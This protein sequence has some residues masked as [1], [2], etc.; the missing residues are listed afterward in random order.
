MKKSIKRLLGILLTASIAAATVFPMQSTKASEINREISN[1]AQKEEENTVS[2]NVPANIAAENA[3]MPSADSYDIDQPVIE[4]FEFLENGQ[5][6]TQNDT[7]HFNM[8]SP[9]L[10][11]YPEVPPTV[12][13]IYISNM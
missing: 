5:A 2:A 8:S 1:V 3:A 4:S 9:L 7:L 10:S 11:C 12:L 13:H 6:L